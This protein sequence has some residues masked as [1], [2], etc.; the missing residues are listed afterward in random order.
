MFARKRLDFSAIQDG[1]RPVSWR[2]ENHLPFITILAEAPRTVAAVTSELFPEI[3]E[4][5]SHETSFAVRQI[6][7]LLHSRHVAPLTQFE[8]FCE[9][10]L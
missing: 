7:D 3:A 5:T 9:S 10:P 1:R 8:S 6:H 2:S 4:K